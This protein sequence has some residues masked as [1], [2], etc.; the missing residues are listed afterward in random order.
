M[1][2]SEILRGGRV[3]EPVADVVVDV[4][5]AHRSPDAV[6]AP[7]PHLRQVVR[8]AEPAKQASQRGVADLYVLLDAG[9]PREAELQLF[10][11]DPEVIATQRQESVGAVAALILLGADAQG[12]AIEQPHGARKQP[13]LRIAPCAQIR[14]DPISEIGE[15]GAERLE[16]SELRAVPSLAPDV[17]IAILPS[18]GGVGAGR[19][20]VA[21]G[22][23]AD[24]HVLPRGRDRERTDPRQRRLVVDPRPRCVE[25]AEAA[26]VSYAL[27]TR[28]VRVRAAE[29]CHAP[30]PG[31]IEAGSNAGDVS[32]RQRAVAMGPDGAR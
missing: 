1:P 32:A 29:A 11:A 5:A 13:W 16:S 22:V 14:G 8:T 12:A 19:L 23:G 18:T 3:A 2:R 17:V 15:R 9:L 20:Q 31:P 10:P 30:L 21:V 28:G 6:V 4:G 24:P 27:E 26:P 25:V 7:G